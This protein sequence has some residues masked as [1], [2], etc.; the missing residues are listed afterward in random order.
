MSIYS[1]IRDEF[2]IDPSAIRKS[3]DGLIN[4]EPTPWN[5]PEIDILDIWGSMSLRAAV[6]LLTGGDTPTTYSKRM[7][8]AIRA[9]TDPPTMLGL[10]DPVVDADFTQALD[11]VRSLR[12]EPV[13][14]EVLDERAVL[15]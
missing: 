9:I 10:K 12:D 2:A 6:G 5:L 15:D 3:C 8:D 14:A 13:D 4:A 7:A 11:V 1:E